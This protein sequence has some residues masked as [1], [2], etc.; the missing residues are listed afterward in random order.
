MNLDG[1][2]NVLFRYF[3]AVRQ[4]I[5]RKYLYFI[6]YNI[7]SIF[8]YR[9][10]YSNRN[11]IGL[12]L[13]KPNESDSPF[14]PIQIETS[15]TNMS[16][17]WSQGPHITTESV[18][19]EERGV[20]ES[21]QNISLSEKSCWMVNFTDIFSCYSCKINICRLGDLHSMC[22]EQLMLIG[23][24]SQNEH[25]PNTAKRRKERRGRSLEL[26]EMGRRVELHP[27][28]ALR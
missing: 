18:C 1:G 8:S 22:L 15:A 2:R 10:I 6:W 13:R 17:H 3:A 16:M 25:W 23:K 27:Q 14:P 26:A 12:H 5:G 21:P 28:E 20:V 11:W 7:I 19:V 4:T 9:I 24:A